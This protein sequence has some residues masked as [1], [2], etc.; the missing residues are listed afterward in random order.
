MKL[1]E[2]LIKM[3]IRLGMPT[4]RIDKGLTFT[5]VDISKKI[6]PKKG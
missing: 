4:S 5:V 2:G 3:C 6:R 1:V